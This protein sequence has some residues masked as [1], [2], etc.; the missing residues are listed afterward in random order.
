MFVPANDS[1]YRLPDIGSCTSMINL[2]PPLKKRERRKKDG[3]LPL[4]LGPLRCPTFTKSLRLCVSSPKAHYQNAC[5]SRAR[6]E[7]CY[8]CLRPFILSER[9]FYLCSLFPSCLLVSERTTCCG[10]CSPSWTRAKQCEA[11][12]RCISM[13]WCVSS[14]IAHVCCPFSFR[15]S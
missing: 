10:C 9:L 2:Y 12:R 8:L 14:S 5:H 13:G 7:R 4:S 1:N 6:P 15:L 3:A 11:G